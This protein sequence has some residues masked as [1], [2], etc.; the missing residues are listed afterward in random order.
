MQRQF[1]GD[2]MTTLGEPS[3]FARELGS[4]FAQLTPGAG[5]S[6]Q[7]PLHQLQHAMLLTETP[8]KRIVW[9]THGPVVYTDN[10]ESLIEAVPL[11]YRAAA[12][13]FVKGSDY[14]DQREYRFAVSTIGTP[15]ENLLAVPI[16]TKLRS[17]LRIVD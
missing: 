6:L 2:C 17:L 5:V 4:A 13:P 14:A 16:T 1:D 12:V 8:F 11:H 7:D 3:E 9:V 10:A 15:A